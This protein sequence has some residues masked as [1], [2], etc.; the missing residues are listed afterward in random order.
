MTRNRGLAHFALCN[1]LALCV[2]SSCISWQTDAPDLASDDPSAT[3]SEWHPVIPRPAA[4]HEERGSFHLTGKTVILADRS[5]WSE[6]ELLAQ[7]LRPATTFPMPVEEIHS[8]GIVDCAIVLRLDSALEDGGD[9]GYTLLVSPDRIEIAASAPAGVFHGCQ[10]LRQLLPH[11]IERD[12]PVSGVGW[13]VSCG[14]IEDCPRFAWRGYMLDS[15]RFF[16]PVEYI[17]RTIDLMARHKLNRFHWH[18]VD[19]QGWRLEIRSHPELTKVGAFRPN[20]NARLNYLSKDPADRYGGYYTQDEVREIVAY[21]RA[22]HVTIIP[23]IEMPGHCLSA[24]VTY[25]KL[26]CRGETP[27]ELGDAWIYRDVYCAGSEATFAFLEDVLIETIKLFPSPWIHVGG[28]ECPKDRWKECPKCQARIRA[29]G[30]KDEDELQSYFIQRVESFLDVRGRRL[31]G[32]DDILQGGLPPR[33]AVQTYR[34]MEYGVEAANQGHDLIVSTHLYCY[35]DYDY[36]GTPVEKSYSFEPAFPE[37]ASDRAN[38]ILGIE[39][40]QWLGNVSRLYLESTDE[41]MPVSRIEYQTYP[42]LLALAEVAWSP[43]EARDWN[44]FWTR[45]R[46]YGERL[47]AMGVGYYRDPRIWT[48]EK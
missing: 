8:G 1:L 47:D 9:E 24:L 29:E 33:A 11:E 41:V 32:W 42:R 31:I 18:L 35:L 43:R 22:R 26:S 45:L 13:S 27:A 37:I 30:L 17:K 40:C 48:G 46:K 16:Q 39:G 19:D 7:S 12:R 36:Q 4:M 23:E 3:P 5:V 44:D 10:T 14:K 34:D 20:A 21:A 6:A 2:F 28:D 25:P 38:R 15:A